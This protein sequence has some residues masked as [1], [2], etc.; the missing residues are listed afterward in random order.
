MI[1]TD[2]LQG[3]IIYMLSRLGYPE[4]LADISICE[5]FLPNAVRKS[6]RYLYLEM[7][8][9]ACSF[10]LEQDLQKKKMELPGESET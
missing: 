1:D 8:S 10:L 3:I 6:S 4:I 2:Q 9:A 5:T 7:V